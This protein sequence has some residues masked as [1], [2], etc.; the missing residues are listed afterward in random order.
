MMTG[1]EQAQ[2][3]L[4][5]ERRAL[6]GRLAD[7]EAEL[8]TTTGAADLWLDLTELHDRAPC[9]YHWVDARGVVVRVN[10]TALGW[11]GVAA[12]QIVGR[13][14]VGDLIVAEGA[15][16]DAAA[17]AADGRVVEGRC[18]GPGDTT[19]PVRVRARALSADRGA[20]VITLDTSEERQVEE[21]L[22]E[23]RDALR[24]ANDAL[25]HAS[26]AKDELLAGMSHELRTPLN[27]VLGLCEALSEG[28]YGEVGDKQVKALKRI[29]ESGR[30][31][32]ALIGDILDLSK[33]E[34]GRLT[35]V[36]E[37][38]SVDEVCRASLRMIQ[39]TAQ[40]KRLSV[41]LQIKDGFSTLPADERRLKQILVNLL[42][43][44]VKFTPEGGSLGLDVAADEGSEGV[45]FT[46]WDTGIGVPLEHQARLFQP[47]VQVD[48]SLS[49]QH[50]GTGL[51]LALVRKLVELHGGGVEMES[52]PGAGSRFSV[53]LPKRRPGR[54]SPPRAGSAQPRALIVE[55]SAPVA[56]Q[57]ARYLAEAGIDAMM[58]EHGDGV[59][60]L[61][62]E[63]QPQLVLLD[64][65]L[66]AE[67]GWDILRELKVD[68][69]TRHIPV[70]VISVLDR[71][72][73]GRALGADGYLV[74]PVTREA[75]LEALA[76]ADGARAQRP[77]LIVEPRAE[78]P[79]LTPA[80]LLLA[81]DDETN[82]A[83]V[84]DFLRARG[85]DVCVAR[86]GREAVTLAHDA[87]PD[88]ILMDIQMPVL[89]GL[90]AIRE[91]RG[92]AEARLRA[93]PI[94]AL[95]ALT[96]TGDRE[97]CL[98]AGADDYLTKPVGLKRLAGVIDALL[99]R[100]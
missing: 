17:L 77:V 18:R 56:E 12:D 96:M 48:S 64:I 99:A 37:P 53:V 22:R 61:A 30:H 49:R 100:R 74:K 42:S 87:R 14:L 13:R 46:V 2:G 58:H 75:L 84:I 67:V 8:G 98:D 24:A 28:V 62:A 41:S 71:P 69:R 97:R 36:T 34:A 63:E 43:N 23:S 26:R 57:L 16:I 95:T 50:T 89:D 20:L 33:I 82:V 35:L 51:G 5:D 52:V 10:E 11:H 3:R 38:V 40:K 39:E 83:T 25:E 54:S 15:P 68:P 4:T 86:N 60:E 47:F 27:A 93:V 70:V 55:D 29:E 85:H 80:R 88:L 66:P 79:E 81:E 1:G 9:G 73:A 76:K 59:V 6:L 32:L 19:R 31:L 90:G 65:L 94:I 92:S 7:I 91:I 45:R 72:D 21:T 78:A 44:A